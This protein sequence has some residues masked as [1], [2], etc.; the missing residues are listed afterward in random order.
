MPYPK[1]EDFLMKKLHY[2]E[3]KSGQRVQR[4][5]KWVQEVSKRDHWHLCLYSNS[6]SHKIWNS[7][8]KKLPY[9]T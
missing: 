3:I 5:S 2:L 8:A 9:T 6:P 1:P 7:D 4:K